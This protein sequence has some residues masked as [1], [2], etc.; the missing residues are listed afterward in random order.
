[1]QV[2]VTDSVRTL[3]HRNGKART[4]SIILFVS[5]NYGVGFGET[6]NVSVFWNE[7][8]GLICCVIF[9]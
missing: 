7:Y 6:G 3:K 9:A 8:A 1:M 2:G 5:G 4:S